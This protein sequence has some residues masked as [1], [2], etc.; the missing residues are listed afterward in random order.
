MFDKVGVGRRASRYLLG[1]S[2]CAGLFSLGP[3]LDGSTAS[4]SWGVSDGAAGMSGSAV[5]VLTTAAMPLTAGGVSGPVYLALGDSLA[6]GFNP[7]LNPTQT[8][9][10]VGYPSEVAAG[11]GEAVVNA[12]CPGE[13]S[14]GFISGTGFDVGCRPFRAAFG[15]HVQYPGTQ[16]SFATDF[17]SSHPQTNL[18]TLGIGTNDIVHCVQKSSDECAR[19]LPRTLATYRSNLDTILTELRAAYSGELV[20]V[21]AYSPAYNDL[22]LTD[23]FSS[24]DAVMDVEARAHRARV[25]GVFDAFAGRAATTV[26]DLCAAGLLVETLH[27]CDIHPTAAG[28]ELLAASV[29]SAVRAGQVALPA[30]DQTWGST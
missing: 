13:S 29:G 15:L 4:P 27:G 19:E 2:L 22:R 20:L 6:F 11:S 26:G 16:L 7:L 24:L 12:A 9:G 14:A 3:L 5:K 30:P 10:F 21:E 25:A 17:L 18:V 1:F 8:A 23:A 28:R